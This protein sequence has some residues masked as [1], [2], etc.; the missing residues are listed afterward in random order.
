[1]RGPT[2]ARLTQYRRKSPPESALTGSWRPIPFG[3]PVPRGPVAMCRGSSDHVPAMPRTAI[4]PD[5]QP[6]LTREGARLGP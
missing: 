4:A 1:M 5:P 6:R 3:L 2:V